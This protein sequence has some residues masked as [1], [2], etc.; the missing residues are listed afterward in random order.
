[1]S[2]LAAI[3]GF[4]IAF[5]L[6]WVY[7]EN[8]GSSALR[9]AGSQGRVV[10]LQVWLF[11]HLPLVIG[12]AGTGVAVK[13]VIVGEATTALPDNE[14]W[15]L[16]GSVA[17]CLIALA[18]LHR[19][20]VIFRCK[21]RAKYR[22]ASAIGLVVLAAIGQGS[23]PVIVIGLVAGISAFQVAQDLYQGHPSPKIS[24]T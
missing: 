22:L 4:A 16:C 10:T 24:G 6:W 2:V 1:M 8:V 3:F 17:L 12:I 20:G 23:M 15:L 5:C 14:R 18:I 19:T 11:G 7:F 13:H 9:T 21:A